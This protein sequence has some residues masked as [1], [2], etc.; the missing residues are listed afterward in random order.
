METILVRIKQAV[1]PPAA[2]Y[3]AEKLRALCAA[4]GVSL[5]DGLGCEVYWEQL[6]GAAALPI[7]KAGSEIA[8]PVDLAARYF[9][10]GIAEDAR[11]AAARAASEERARAARVAAELAAARAL[12]EEKQGAEGEE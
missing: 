9:T 7:C 8:L 3:G 12:V 5:P 11:S 4:A 1:T 2:V 6:E 10:A